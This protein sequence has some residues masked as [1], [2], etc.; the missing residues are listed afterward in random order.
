[1]NTVIRVQ[2][3]TNWEGKASFKYGEMAIADYNDEGVLCINDG[4]PPDSDLPW[5]GFQF[6]CRFGMLCE[7]GEP[8]VPM[9]RCLAAHV[10]LCLIGWEDETGCQFYV[11][12]TQEAWDGRSEGCTDHMEFALTNI[13][14][15]MI[16]IH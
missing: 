6:T 3:K 10:N 9:F 4:M 13:C 5:S 8:Y 16:F 1:M 2:I 12:A 11:L 15:E 7:I 14:H